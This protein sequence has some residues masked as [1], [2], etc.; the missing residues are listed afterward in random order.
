MSPRLKPLAPMPTKVVPKAWG[1]EHWIVNREYCGKKMILKQ[2]YHRHF[3]AR[4]RPSRPIMLAD[5]SAVLSPMIAGLRLATA[6][7]LPGRPRPDHRQLRR[8]EQAARRLLDLGDPVEEIPWTGTR[9]CLPG[10]LPL[11]REA[12]RHPGL[13]LH[14][15]HGHQGFTLGPA[16]AW[17]LAEAMEGDPQAVADKHGYQARF[18]PVGPAH[19]ELG[20]PTQM[21][22]FVR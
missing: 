13:W 18:L 17:R 5:Q 2:G 9:P 12:P 11:V 3:A 8:A 15:G 4:E 14:F 1:E 19:P 20:T 10:M 21:A 16:T 7:E 6:V 22:V